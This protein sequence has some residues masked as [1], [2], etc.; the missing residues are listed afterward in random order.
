MGTLVAGGGRFSLTALLR[1]EGDTRCE[2][3]GVEVYGCRGGRGLGDRKGG[4]ARGGKSG[5][6]W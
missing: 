1:V 5:G 6:S 2:W 3:E 4:Q